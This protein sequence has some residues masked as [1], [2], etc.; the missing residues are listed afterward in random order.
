MPN[1]VKKKPTRLAT[2]SGSTLKPVA[3]FIAW[4]TSVRSV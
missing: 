3:M 1:S 4:R 2:F